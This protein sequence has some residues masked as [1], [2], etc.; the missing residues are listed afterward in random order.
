MKKCAARYM[1]AGLS[2]RE[3]SIELPGESSAMLVVRIAPVHDCGDR[4]VR[5]RGSSRSAVAPALVR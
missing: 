2:R 1:K 3:G 5:A 4:R